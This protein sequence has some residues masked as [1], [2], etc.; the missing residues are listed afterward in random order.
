MI[1]VTISIKVQHISYILSILS[2]SILKIEINIQMS[3][4]MLL[5]N[6]FGICKRT[7]F[8]SLIIFFA[9]LIIMR[10]F[11]GCFL[12]YTYAAPAIPIDA[13]AKPATT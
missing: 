10:D 9:S 2:K 11:I 13:S 4:R 8:K 5:F 12:L 6:F 7:Y 3:M 1:G